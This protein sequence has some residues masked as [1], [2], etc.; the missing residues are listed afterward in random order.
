M[1]PA[2]DCAGKM[3]VDLFVAGEMFV[4]TEMELLIEG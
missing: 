3:F 4:E 1:L 2:D